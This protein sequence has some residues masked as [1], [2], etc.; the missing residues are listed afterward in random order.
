MEEKI[1]K[2]P[3]TI[4]ELTDLKNF[5][6]DCGPDIEKKK[7]EID[8]CM[9]IYKIL[10]EFNF[11]MGP[12]DLNAKWELYGAPQRIVKLMEGRT[13]ELEKLKEQMIKEMETE[14]EDFEEML[15]NLE[16]TVGGFDSNKRL[17]KYMDIASE[18]DNID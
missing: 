18:V 8:D 17:D 11:E 12:V 16:L 5:I 1:K 10:D 7:K 15:D 2:P 9:K 14:Q 6:K 13:T 3:T 4:D